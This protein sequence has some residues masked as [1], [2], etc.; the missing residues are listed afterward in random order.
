[1]LTNIHRILLGK[2]SPCHIWP[3]HNIPK[4][5]DLWQDGT[6]GDAEV[7]VGHQPNE[8]GE[9]EEVDRDPKHP[10]GHVERPRGR[11]I[12]PEEN[13]SLREYFHGKIFPLA[14]KNISPGDIY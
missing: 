1:M 12:Y 4:V 8:D 3:A 11:R 13:L 7:V 14:K 6:T 2:Y 9:E 10:A 5:I